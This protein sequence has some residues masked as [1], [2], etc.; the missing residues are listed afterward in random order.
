M[1]KFA[2]LG[3]PEFFFIVNFQVS[4]FHS[5][6][7]NINIMIIIFTNLLPK[8]GPWYKHVYLGILLHDENSPRR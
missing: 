6:I 3:G 1:Q 4:L 2:D 5:V 8:S 7:I